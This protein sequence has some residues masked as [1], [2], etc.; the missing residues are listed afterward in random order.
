MHLH[1]RKAVLFLLAFIREQA[2]ETAGPLHHLSHVYIYIYVLHFTN[3]KGE[4]S[5][6]SLLPRTG[7]GRLNNLSSR[8]KQRGARCAW[9]Y[10]RAWR[11][12]GCCCR[13]RLAGSNPAHSPQTAAATPPLFHGNPPRIC[14][15]WRSRD[16]RS[17]TCG[18]ENVAVRGWGG[19]RTFIYVAIPI[20]CRNPGKGDVCVTASHPQ[21]VT[22]RHFFHSFSWVL[23]HSKN[24]LQ[25]I[26]SS[27][28]TFKV[29]I[30]WRPDPRSCGCRCFLLKAN[31]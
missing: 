15:R 9:K 28:P 2:E 12:S 19:G 23:A 1:N 5:H 7:F 16:N 18:G 31:F 8:W 22:Q 14:W 24:P 21:P 30:P 27:I 26:L 3:E 4:S 20:R 11:C 6:F 10:L 29:S 17:T 13:H 25:G